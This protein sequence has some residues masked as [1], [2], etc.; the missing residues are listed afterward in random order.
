MTRKQ[1]AESLGFDI[2]YINI[3]FE[4]AMKEHPELIIEDETMNRKLGIGIDYTL[5]QVL[6]GMSYIRNGKGLTELEKIQLEEDFTMRTNEV[7]AIGIPGT[8]EFLEHLKNRKKLKCC[9]TCSYCIKSTIRSKTFTL[10][11]FCNLW[12]R[13]LHV[14]KA[15]PY[16]DHC[17]QWE[18][19]G[20]EPLIFYTRESPSN[21]DI[22]GNVKNEVMGFDV[23]NFKK[24]SNS[25]TRLVTDIGVGEL[26]SC[27]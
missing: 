4:K 20:K 1:I 8:E 19:S 26:E 12:E 10:K 25:K 5:E 21:L 7:K 15:D 17:R 24:E 13:F 6:L 11:P 16:K 23:S 14:M 2:L 27:I 9:A 18:Y 3:T 22:Y